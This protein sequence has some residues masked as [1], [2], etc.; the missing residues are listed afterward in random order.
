LHYSEVDKKLYV[1]DTY[2]HKLKTIDLSQN[3]ENNVFEVVSW[4]GRT[5]KTPVLLDGSK[6]VAE[7]HEPYGL[8]VYSKDGITN[9]CV[10]LADTSSSCIR[11]V[12]MEGDVQTLEL[13][14]IP[15]ANVVCEGDACKPFFAL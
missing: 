7:L 14:G 6:N 13:I 9:D 2:N 5:T 3:I 8:W 15:P 11:R 10:Y 4:V 1:A 12:S